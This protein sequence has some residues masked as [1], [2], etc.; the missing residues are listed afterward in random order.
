MLDF[1]L[2]GALS[3]DGHAHAG[4][5]QARLDALRSRLSPTAVSTVLFD[6]PIAG[7]AAIRKETGASL[8]EAMAVAEQVRAEP[9][10]AA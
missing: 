6:E 5:D 8:R 2:G 10:D 7:I 9:P 3:S 1:L 4:L